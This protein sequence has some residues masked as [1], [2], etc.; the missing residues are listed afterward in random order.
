MQPNG[1]VII[2]DSPVVLAAI[3]IRDTPV[4]VGVG[5][6]G[7]DP[8]RCVE[9]LNCSIVI[10]HVSVGRATEDKRQGVI[11]LRKLSRLDQRRTV[12]QRRVRMARDILFA[13][14]VIYCEL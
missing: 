1:L 11:I 13:L 14:L 9:V 4:V 7:F 5:N 6:F 10:P 8:Y 12:R 3:V 2:L